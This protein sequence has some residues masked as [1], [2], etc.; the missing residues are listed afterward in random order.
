ML[1]RLSVNVSGTEG[2]N[3]RNNVYAAAIPPKVQPPS[4]KIRK[5]GAF[6]ASTFEAASRNPICHMPSQNSMNSPMK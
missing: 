1:L 2:R 4:Q 5:A 6:P 3:I